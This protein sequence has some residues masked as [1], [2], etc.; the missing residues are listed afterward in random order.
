MSETV[1][2][3]KNIEPVFPKRCM[4]CLQKDNIGMIGI[5]GE[6][7]GIMG[8]FKWI[9]GKSGKRPVP[10]HVG[11]AR[12]LKRRGFWR[13]VGVLILFTILPV[14]WFALR[15]NGVQMPFEFNKLSLCIAAVI[16]FLPIMIAEELRPAAFQFSEGEN[17]VTY[18]F[19]DS[20]YAEEF[21]RL[22]NTKTGL[23]AEFI[24][25]LGKDLTGIGK[26]IN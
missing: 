7:A 16:L 22:N 6:A 21:A 2:L 8:Y 17:I 18:E 10:A 14:G 25:E 3:P 13:N 19:K 23:S 20:D 24:E 15:V 11:C 9:T 1:I 4:V 5:R 12:K 26:K